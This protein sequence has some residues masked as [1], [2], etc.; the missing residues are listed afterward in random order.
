MNN[1]E[2]TIPI[3]KSGKSD[4]DFELVKVQ[5]YS[6]RVH[7]FLSGGLTF[8]FV[9]FGL[10]AIFYGI[11]FQG[12]F[13]NKYSLLYVGYLG[14]Y[15]IIGLALAAVVYIVNQYNVRMRLVSKMLEDINQGKSLPPLNDLKEYGKR[16]G[17]LGL[18]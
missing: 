15:V 7:A 14:I 8:A 16:K 5:I 3:K 4:K 13:E 11:F 17:C 10:V 6:D 1:D 12:F 9:I 18:D 2:K